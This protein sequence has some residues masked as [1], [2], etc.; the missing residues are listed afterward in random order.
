M[1]RARWISTA[2]GLI[3]SSYA[4]DLFCLPLMSE[5][6]SRDPKAFE[7]SRFPLSRE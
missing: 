4:I 6:E 7:I 5:A 3:P 1:M 2:R